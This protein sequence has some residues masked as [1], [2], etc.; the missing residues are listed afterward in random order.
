MS[1]RHS[2]G[3]S[4]GRLTLVTAVAASAVASTLHAAPASATAGSVSFAFIGDLPYTSAQVPLLPAL[5]AN[6]NADPDVEFVAHSGDFKGGS[7]SCSDA[8]FQS[9]F[10]GFQALA[11]PF[12]YTPGDNDWTDC[13]RTNNGGF[14]PADRLAKVRS[15]YFS[16]PGQTTG[17]S[18]MAVDTQATSPI[19]ADRPYVENTW[20]NKQCVTFGDIHSVS[21]GNGRLTPLQIP[22]TA[23]QTADRLAEVDARIAAD[24]R[25]IDTIF[26]AAVAN[27]SE[28]VFLMMQAEP[29]DGPIDNDKVF[30]DE[31]VAIRAKIFARSASFGKPVILAHGDQHN[32]LITPNYGGQPNITRYENW[33][34]NTGGVLAVTKWIKVTATCGSP[35]VFSQATMTVGSTPPPVVPEGPLTLG[36]LGL[37]VVAAAI[38]G[39]RQRQ[40]A[41]R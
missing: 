16:A 27:N 38:L 7:D 15:L 24:V 17:G 10:T 29:L 5:V 12:W 9:T 33:G 35:S 11:D 2:I 23:Q 3:R 28:G 30:G 6:I 41:R 4:V 40:L 18:P 36:L 34:S 22:E 25:W 32:Y 37:G 39:V 20:F 14:S 1:R 31:F 8:A 13:H 19:A 26:D 21:S